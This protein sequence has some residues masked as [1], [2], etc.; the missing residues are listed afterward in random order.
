MELCGLG[1]MYLLLYL[2]FVGISPALAIL[3]EPGFLNNLQY[4]IIYQLRCGYGL[5]ELIGF[6]ETPTSPAGFPNCHRGPRASSF[7]PTCMA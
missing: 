4:V 3:I 6:A 1:K 5:H 7:L 2:A